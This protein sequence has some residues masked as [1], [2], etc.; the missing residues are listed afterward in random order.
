[1]PLFFVKTSSSVENSY[2]LKIFFA[3]VSLYDDAYSCLFG[4]FEIKSVTLTCEQCGLSYILHN[5][6]GHDERKLFEKAKC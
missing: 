6:I 2:L 4:T 3:T 5:Y 1:M